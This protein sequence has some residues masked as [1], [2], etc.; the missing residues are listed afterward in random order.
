MKLSDNALKVLEE[1]YFLRDTTGSIKENWEQLCKRVA[2]TIAADEPKEKRKEYEISYFDLMY[3]QHFLPNS[4]CLMN[5][6]K[7]RGMYSACFVLPMEDS[8]EAIMDTLKH[9]GM[10]HKM[11]GGTGFNFSK[12]RPSGSLIKSTAGTSPGPT[13]FI[14]MF[15]GV[16][17]HIKQGGTRRGANIALLSVEHPDILKFISFKR[18]LTRINNFNIS[19]AITDKFMKALE[20]DEEYEL[21]W[22]GVLYGKLSAKKVFDLIVEN[23]WNTGEPGLFFIDTVHKFNEYKEEPITGVNP[24]GESPLRDMESC[25]LG[26]INLSNFIV[27]GLFDYK[28][29]EKVVRLSTRFLDSVISQNTYPVES[30]TKA[31]EETRKIG[32]GIMGWADALIKM[33]ITYGSDKSLKEAKKVMSFI[34]TISEN[35]SEVLGKEKGI[36]PVCKKLGLLRRNLWTTIIA[37]TGTISMIADTSGGIEPLFSIGYVKTVM[38]GKKLHYF[39]KLF[40]EQMDGYLTKELKDQICSS[41]SLQGLEGIPKDLKEIFVTASDVSPKDHIRMQAAF[42]KHTHGGISKTVNL[43]KT[44]KK[45]EVEDAFKLAYTSGCKG[46]TVYRDGSRQHQVLSVKKEE[47]E[48]VDDKPRVRYRKR[49]T[50]G[51]TEKYKTPLGNLYFT[52]NKNKVDDN[53]PVEVILSMGKTGSV[54]QSFMEAIGRLISVGL[55]YYVPPKALGQAITGIETTE[56]LTFDGHRRTTYKSIPD[57]IGKELLRNSKHEIEEETNGLNSRCPQCNKELIRQEGCLKCTCGYS[58]C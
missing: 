14:D 21:T 32:L 13:S 31:T 7:P 42:Q 28:A 46:V 6:G 34:K 39:N 9:T 45:K 1:R 4:P 41:L 2:K 49:C 57:L 38:E 16:T 8:M 43:P 26:S 20:K 33:G 11:G 50:V 58:K 12:L 24:C 10:V 27:N 15:D 17:E 47:V 23:A 36:C 29:L 51:T 53:E 56:N 35:E 30:I 18:D 40:S 55:K 54:V 22:Q 52:I 3:N 19:V 37:P 5:A 48:V 25:N 44:A